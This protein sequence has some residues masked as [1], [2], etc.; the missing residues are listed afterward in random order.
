MLLAGKTCDLPYLR[1]LSELGADPGITNVDGTTPL[2]AAAGVGVLAVG[3]EPGTVEEV[4]ETVDFLLS[5]GCDL[6]AVDANGETVMH[7]AA[8][9]NYPETVAYLAELGADPRTWNHKNKWGWTPVMIAQGQRP[10][11]FK[12]S[13]ETV[14]ALEAA[15]Q[16]NLPT[17][18]TRIPVQR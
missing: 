6:N 10:G 16:V 11:S 15:M 8:Y 17:E 5:L 2:I 1:L 3:E 13:P 18:S 14:A 9:R 4:K 7:G 12:P